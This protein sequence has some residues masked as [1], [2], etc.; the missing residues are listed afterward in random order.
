[1][2]K[3]PRR[4]SKEGYGIGSLQRGNWYGGITFEM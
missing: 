4:S 1:V 3:H 2:G